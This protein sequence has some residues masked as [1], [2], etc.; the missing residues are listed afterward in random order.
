MRL[1]IAR[2]VSKDMCG[3]VYARCVRFSLAFSNFVG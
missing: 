1:G 2:E 3:L